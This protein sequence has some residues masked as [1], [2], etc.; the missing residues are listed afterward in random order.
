MVRIPNPVLTTTVLVIMLSLAAAQAGVA[1]RRLAETTVSGRTGDVYLL[2]GL[3]NVFSQ[4]LDTLAG[5]LRSKGFQ[6][7]AVNH[8]RRGSVADSII[9][10]YKA[11]RNPEPVY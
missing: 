7:Q 6:A 9:D 4:G 1:Q 11:A 8:S 5:A 3:M 2:R 10:R